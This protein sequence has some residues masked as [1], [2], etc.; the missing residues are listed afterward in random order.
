[1]PDADLRVGDRGRLG[2]FLHH[3]QH[4]GQIGLFADAQA[5]GRRR[6]LRD[7]VV[8]GS[9]LQNGEIHRD[10]VAGLGEHV[11]GGDLVHELHGG[12]AALARGDPGVRRP[13][14]DLDVHRR[15]ALA[16]DRHDV[17]QVAGLQVQLHVRVG[18]Q[19][20]DQTLRARRAALLRGLDQE[21]DLLE[22]L[23]AQVMQDLQG[24]DPLN[25]AALLVGDARPV[26]LL[27]VHAEG[28]LGDR[29]RSEDR[30][31]MADQQ[32]AALTGP[33]QR[34]DRVFRQTLGLG[35]HALDGEAQGLQPRGQDTRDLAAALHVAGPR[36]D[37]H[38]LL[39]QLELVRPGGLRRRPDLGVLGL[40]LGR[41]LCG[42]VEKRGCAGDRDE[43]KLHGIPQ[44]LT[45]VTMPGR[46]AGSSRN[47]GAASGHL[48]PWPSARDI[49]KGMSRRQARQRFQ[50]GLP[51][52]A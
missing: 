40:G 12:V 42:H 39:E 23:E 51:P 37:V 17:G 3:G 35:L 43:S 2:V 48:A 47:D 46:P 7:D 32:D 1:M 28:P 29:A 8:P 19:L 10:P 20:A 4:L 25:H 16:P 11:V 6:V 44:L 15:G 52:Y 9:R 5:V 41:R 22:V 34:R 50:E 13:A 21:D 38:D 30:V 26:G 24:V 33:L 18:D 14:L 31:D 49:V 36:I 45:G 27:G